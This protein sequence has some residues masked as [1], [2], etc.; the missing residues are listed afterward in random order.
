MKQNMMKHKTLAVAIAALGVGLANP[1][2]AFKFELNDGISGSFDS[3]ISFGAQ[4]RKAE[5]TVG[6]NNL[7]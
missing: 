5:M 6:T 2:A 7:Q 4:R 1:A 3:T